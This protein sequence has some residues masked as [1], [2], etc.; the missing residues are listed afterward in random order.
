MR[1]EAGTRASAPAPPGSPGGSGWIWV[2]S[3]SGSGP[4]QGLGTFRGT[5]HVALATSHAHETEYDRAWRG[6]RGR[7]RYWCR[8]SPTRN[9]TRALRGT[10]SCRHRA[11]AVITYQEILPRVDARAPPERRV[12]M[13]LVYAR[14]AGLDVHKATVVGCVRV[15][16][17]GRGERHTETRTLATTLR[18]LE[19]LTTWLT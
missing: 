17:V 18:G 13:N 10:P 3:G 7:S 14:C 6:P 2:R 19:E 9:L 5:R 12:L 15:P 8:E 1:A 16:G 4:P 11:C